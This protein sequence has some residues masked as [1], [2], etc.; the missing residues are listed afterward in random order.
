MSDGRTLEQGNRDNGTV[1]QRWWDSGPS[2]GGTVKQ[3]WRNR[4]SDGGTV[5]RL[6]V[7]HWKRGTEI[8]GQ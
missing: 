4:I 1:E 7:E 3:A 5:E 2:D 6:M 8:M